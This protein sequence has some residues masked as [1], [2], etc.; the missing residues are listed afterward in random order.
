M[1]IIKQISEN[2]TVLSIT[3]L[4]RLNAACAPELRKRLME[5]I[6]D[7]AKCAVVNMSDIR[8]IDSSGLSVFI[9]LNKMLRA[10]DGDM[11]LCGLTS[12]V[13]ATFELTRLHRVF[14]ILPDEASAISAFKN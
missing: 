13:Q 14:D 6:G 12:T 4:E 9:S 7:E 2:I 3:E 5:L 1:K 11:K 10:K 8:Y